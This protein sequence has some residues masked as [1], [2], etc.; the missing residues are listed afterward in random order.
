MCKIR[1][2]PAA[3]LTAHSLGK[4]VHHYCFQREEWSLSGSK[5][6]RLEN[7]MELFFA[8][9]F[10]WRHF[11]TVW[12]LEL[13]RRVLIQALG[14]GIADSILMRSI[15]R[16]GLLLPVFLYSTSP[17]ALFPELFESNIR[18][19]MPFSRSGAASLLE[20][21]QNSQILLWS[22]SWKACILRENNRHATVKFTF[23]SQNPNH[24]PISGL[25][26]RVDKQHRT[27][28]REKS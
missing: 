4:R 12:T 27:P 20:I 10:S 2:K 9:F 22:W 18:R 1:C 19:E 6:L 17:S 28:D 7:S 14:S 8:C 25:I 23:L 21:A 24:I 3:D 11:P 16:Y 15:Q 13:F 26:A 5:I